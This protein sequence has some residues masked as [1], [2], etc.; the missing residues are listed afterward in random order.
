MISWCHVSYILVSYSATKIVAQ[1]TLEI[2]HLF[3]TASA[4]QLIWKSC[5]SASWKRIFSDIKNIPRGNE[6]L[7]AETKYSPRKWDV[8]ISPRPQNI[9]RSQNI[10]PAAKNLPRGREIIPRGKIIPRGP[11]NIPRGKI[12]PA[13]EKLFP[14]AQ[15][16]F[17]AAQKIFPAEKIFPAAQ[18]IFPAEKNIPRGP[19]NIPRGKKIFFSMSLP[20]FRR[21]VITVLWSNLPGIIRYLRKPGRDIEK[22]IFFPRGIFSGPRGIFFPRGI[23]SGPR[24][25]FFPRGIFSGPRGIISRPRGIFFRGE[26]FLGC[27]E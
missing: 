12:F 2:I 24:G 7:P 20:G 5:N 27:G 23:F 16:I 17:P 8:K 14:A 25:I 9:R 22:N 4:H 6:I 11:E 26:Y 15:K 19:E 10:F 3:N 1:N 21:Y 13:T 18:K